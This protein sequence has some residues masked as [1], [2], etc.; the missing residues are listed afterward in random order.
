MGLEAVDLY[1]RMPQHM[2]DEVSHICVLNA[3]S[4]AGLIEQAQDIFSRIQK[5]TEQI[6]VTMVNTE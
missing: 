4:H 2:R 5:K 1:Q 6:F 3:C